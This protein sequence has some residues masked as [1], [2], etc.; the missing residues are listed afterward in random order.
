MSGK[1]IKLIDAK[2]IRIMKRQINKDFEACCK[3]YNSS[4][5]L[6]DAVKSHEDNSCAFK[7]VLKVN[8]GVE[9]GA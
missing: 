8:G 4:V 6:I 5:D 3:L 1:S 9:A 2:G 7:E